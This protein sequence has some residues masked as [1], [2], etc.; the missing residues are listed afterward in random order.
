MNARVNALLFLLAA[1]ATTA[2]VALYP[3]RQ[4]PSPG[5]PGAWKEW[6]GLSSDQKRTRIIAY[7]DLARTPEGIA[8]LD[9]AEAFVK[10]PAPEQNA[11]RTAAAVLDQ[12][13]ARQSASERRRLLRIPAEAR[14]L[15][16]FRTLS[17][18]ERAELRALQTD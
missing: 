13:L 6:R 2:A 17:P 10:L 8:A 11:L 14:A 15:E 12:A 18:D 1:C 16:L 9:A 5:L 3:A 4:E 7:E